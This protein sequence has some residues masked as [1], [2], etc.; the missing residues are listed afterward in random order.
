MI[1]PFFK[2]FGPEPDTLLA[3]EEI[4]G[5]FTLFESNLSANTV[6]V[7]NLVWKIFR[8]YNN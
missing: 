2:S 4:T 1:S 7:E 5:D 6:K 3:L 8:K